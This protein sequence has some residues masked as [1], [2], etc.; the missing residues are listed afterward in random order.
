MNESVKSGFLNEIFLPERNVLIDYDFR[1]PTQNTNYEI[2]P[3][4]AAQGYLIYNLEI[5]TGDQYGATGN[6]IDTGNPALSYS[7]SSN[8]VFDIVSGHFNGTSKLNI[9]G[10]IDSTDWTAY[11]A[12][13]HLETGLSSESKVIFSSKPTLNSTSGFAFGINGCN[14]LFFEYQIGANQKRIYTLNK[15]LD[16]KNLASISK[17]DSNLYIGLH[18]YQALNSFSVEEKFGLSNYTH[19]SSFYL[20]GLGASGIDYRNY[21]GYID[22]FMLIDRGLDFPERNTFSE[23]FFCSGYALE[24]ITTTSSQSNS[25]TG[26]DYQN[27]VVG[28]GITGYEEYLKG[29]QVVNGQNVP[30]YSYSGVTGLLYETQIVELTGAADSTGLTFTESPASGL[31]DYSYVMEY[32]NS[33]ILSFNNFDDSYKEVYSFSGKNTDDINL[34][35]AF[36]GDIN[37][38]SILPT[39]NGEAVN[40]YVNGLAE[41]FV[42]SL[43]SNLTG[44]FKV[45]GIYLESEDFF[46]RDD[47]AIYDLVFG[48]SDSVD[49][50]AV[51]E[52]AGYKDLSYSFVGE[53]DLHLNGVKLISGIDY[54]DNS[55]NI[56]VSPQNLS[57]GQILALPAHDCNLTRYT[58]CNDNNFDTSVPLFDEQV[59]VNGL[60]QIKL[61]DYEKLPDFSFKYTSF[62]LD[63]F[64]DTVYNNDT[65]YF[66]V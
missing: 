58:G 66:N 60:R 29:Y 24:S 55:S 26:V 47:I 28:T 5:P 10:D 11:I 12:F 62:S 25:V 15:E 63:P 20:G 35:S 23:A 57:Q 31:A 18:Q 44:E 56:R 2:I 16:N 30:F 36:I 4:N 6:I 43:T 64:P 38:F 21:S 52:A 48:S 39:G 14:R 61:L 42:T 7:D 27:V 13:K 32:A 59:W 53:K 9:L 8:V 19:S 45:S 1:S 65:G 37:K 33:K 22:Q 46:D 40:L 54:S 17:I 41:P 34:D 3:T 50:T 49:V 51:D